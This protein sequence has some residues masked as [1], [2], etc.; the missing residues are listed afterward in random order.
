MP[1][2]GYYRISRKCSSLRAQ[3]A[4]KG[5]LQSHLL[6]SMRVW[7]NS[8]QWIISCFPCQQGPCN[9]L[10]HAFHCGLGVEP[11]ALLKRSTA[12]SFVRPAEHYCRTEEKAPDCT[13]LIL[14]YLFCL[15]FSWTEWDLEKNVM[16]RIFS[17]LRDKLPTVYI[18]PD[19]LAFSKW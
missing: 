2:E 15:M 7:K 5:C 19:M 10:P 17:R 18:E 14:G 1:C 12:S 16:W 4:F 9:V 3:E 6:V 11:I 13:K 8:H